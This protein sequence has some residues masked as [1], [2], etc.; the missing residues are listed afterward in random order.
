MSYTTD[1][2]VEHREDGFGIG[3]PEP[4]LSWTIV[5]AP[6]GVAQAAYDI[7]IVR[8]HGAAVATRV[9]S[10]LSV[11]V[12]WV[13]EPLISRET[14][15]VRV[16]ARLDDG[17]VTN[18]S[19]SLRIEAGLL[20]PAD[21]AVDFVSP[22]LEAPHPSARPAYLL[23]SEFTV[24]EAVRAARIY[25]TAHGVF[26]LEVNGRTG[27][28]I[29]SPGWSSYRHRLRYRTVDVTEMIQPG[30]NAL[31]VWLADGW[32]RGRLGFNGGLWDNYG[33][34]VS[35]LLQLEITD[36]EGTRSVPLSWTWAESPITATGLYEG[37][38]HDHRLAIDGWSTAGPARG[39]WTAATT[40]NLD[41]FSH[42]LEAPTGPPVRVTETLIPISIERRTNGRLRLDFGQNIS[43][44]IGFEVTAPA[45]H[46]IELHHA[47][48]LEDDELAVR[49]LRTATSVDV[50]IS[51]GGRGERWMPRFTLHGF[52][53]AE[54]VG[55]PEDQDPAALFASVVH[56]DMTRT[57]WFSSSNEMLD[58]FHE[59]VVWS[60]RDN[61]VDLPTDCPQR[62]ER[63]GWSGDIQV[64]APT[65][66]YLY[67]SIGV[68]T[69]WLRDLAAEQVEHGSV[70]NF[71][72]WIDCGFPK[73]PAAA[74]GDAA[75]IVPWVLYQRTGDRGLLAE[76]FASMRAWVDQVTELAD[77]SGL[78]DTGFQLGDW[79]DPAA[80]PE[81]PGDS[82]TDAYLVATAH[83]ARSAAIVAETAG[84]LGDTLSRQRYTVVAERARSAFQ[85][86]YVAPGGRVVSDT[87][88]SLAIAIA[89]DL[90]ANDEQRDAAG[91]RLS[92]LVQNGG[93]LIQTGF[94]GTPIVCDALA[95]TGH[96]DDAY[97][98]LLQTEAPSWLYAVTMG[99]TTVW[100]RW[101]SMRPDG[102]LNP[103]E[104]TSFN[105]Y[106]LG[107][108]ADFMHRRI[109]GLEPIEPG[110]RRVRIAPQPG[111]KLTHAAAEHLS[112]YG[113]IS[114]RWNRQDG[115]LTVHVTI[116]TGVTADVVLPGADAQIV[117]AGSHTFTAPIRRSED[118]PSAPRRWN[119]HN[120]EERRQMIESG[121][122]S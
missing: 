99:A 106:A 5:D 7:E 56:S 114:T 65:A 39:D 87:V 82:A 45:G 76:Q 110:Y 24:D 44:R 111:G 108:V 9:L 10:D 102:S 46:R 17:R 8:S 37:E 22:S 48:V 52:R 88:T 19:R 3:V 6:H 97:H 13:G 66:A 120:P 109:G 49:P 35:L 94:V 73:D 95:Q 20:Q 2:R 30:A 107:A 89:F 116:P 113:L 16:R 47:E 38:Q 77:S 34:D 61:F 70:L 100:E 92:E 74:W 91:R 105:H 55:W 50:Y 23:R 122:A 57:G 68:L 43:G 117:H 25:A 58:R 11:L 63:L 54:V 71:H 90:L 53:F 59:N 29:L 96:M 62:D 28:E 51:A 31:G 118:D 101:D 83:Y 104:M 12:P 93:Y 103:G 15:D 18:W 67:D 64:F 36:D 78:W 112:P 33:S 21:W 98:L 115:L 41:E 42:R 84:V 119:I 26:D 40:V 32:F 121:L 86:V 75:V 4:R 1:L 80:P 69:N 60:M 72:P 81:R 14:A 79:L 27:S 85:H